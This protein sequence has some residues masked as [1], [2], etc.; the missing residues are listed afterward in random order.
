MTDL[1]ERE[2]VKKA[3]LEKAFDK[4]NCGWR[5]FKEVAQ[6]VDSVSTHKEANETT[7]Y[8]R[9]KNMTLEEMA[10]LLYLIKEGDIP[11]GDFGEGDC[12]GD[13]ECCLVEWLKKE[14]K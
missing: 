14:N 1:I 13:C 5:R 9:I 11:C 6:A 10:R 12:Y 7:N 3:I 8:G 2:E 4:D